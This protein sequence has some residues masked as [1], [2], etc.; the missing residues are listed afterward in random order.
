MESHQ[1]VDHE[2]KHETSD[3]DGDSMSGHVSSDS[4]Q[5]CHEDDVVASDDDVLL[6]DP[7]VLTSTTSSCSEHADF[8]AFCQSAFPAVNN[9]SGELVL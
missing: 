2:S 8:E 1:L 7:A 4:D 5:L 6:S 9:D 3:D